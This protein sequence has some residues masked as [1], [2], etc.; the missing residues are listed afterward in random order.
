MD[1]Y[2]YKD[3]V[4]GS[5]ASKQG[6]RIFFENEARIMFRIS[7]TGSQGATIR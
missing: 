5:V 4:D 7:G 1:E 2:T 6:I 3:P